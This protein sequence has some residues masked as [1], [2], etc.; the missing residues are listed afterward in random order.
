MHLLPYVVAYGSVLVFAVAV[1]ARILTF[2]RMPMHLRWEL[3][4]VAHEGK[5]SSYGGSYLEEFEWWTKPRETSLLGEMK[6]MAAEILFLVA[7]WENNRRLWRSSFPFH[8]GLY[9]VIASTLLMVGAG[10]LTALWPSPSLMHRVLSAGAAILGVAGLCLGIL[11]A[12]GLLWKRLTRSELKDYTA[13]ADTFNLCFFVVAF[14]CA[15][16]N[17]IASDRN[18]SQ[19]STFVDNLVMFRLGNLPESESGTG[20]FAVSV[21]LL[22]LLLA[23]IPMTHMS[24][25]IGKYFAYHAVRWNDKPNLPGGKDERTIVDLLN[26]PVGWAAPHI[27]EDG[28]GKTW[29]EV[30]TNNPHAVEKK[31]DGSTK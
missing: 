1:V 24:H 28:E 5:R 16:L 17:F 21:V 10:I 23:Y 19:V 30:A 31:S 9:L 8:F 13:R 15:L 11:G 18:F 6:V 25:F 3:Y 20:L 12:L 27:Q 2:A 26:K 29:A 22:S 4:P 7:L 14:G